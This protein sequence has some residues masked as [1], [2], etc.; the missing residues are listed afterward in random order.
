MTTKLMPD[1][2]VPSLSVPTVGGGTWTLSEQSP[3]NF[4]MVVV[5]RGY[6]CPLCKAYLGKLNELAAQYEEA[7]VSVIALSMDTEDRAKSAKDEWGLSNLT[8]GYGL[9]EATARAWGLWISSAIREGEAK[10]FAEPG[11]FWVRPSGELYLIDISNMPF[12]R[13]DLE[14]L[15]GKV[16]F[17]VEKGYPA[18]GS[19]KAAA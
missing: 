17:V 4:T 11:L 7:G 8:I 16:G 19:L 6:H 15:L 1:A 9:D 13:P 2:K 3:Q 14:G 18:R 10:T 12:A 5:Y